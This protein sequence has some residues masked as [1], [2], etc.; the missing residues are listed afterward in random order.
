VL[1][2]LHF[3]FDLDISI[4]NIDP[5]IDPAWTERIRSID[6]RPVTPHYVINP[7]HLSGG[8]T[9]EGGRF[10]NWFGMTLGHYW[11]ATP[12]GDVLRYS[13]ET[14]WR[15]SLQSP[16]VQ[17]QVGRLFLDLQDTIPLSLDSVPPDIAA[18]VSDPDWYARSEAWCTI[19]DENADDCEFRRNLWDDALEWWHERV[20]DTSYLIG[21]QFFQMWRVKDDVFLRWWCSDK[22][23]KSAWRLPEGQIKLNVADFISSCYSFLDGFITA[24][25]KRVDGIER[26]G[27]H[28]A[29][30]YLNVAEV[31]QEQL[32]MEAL[33]NG[34]KDRRPTTDW[35]LVRS[36]LDVL[37]SHLE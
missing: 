37:R 24:M 30:C 21:G 26:D 25:R 7:S 20:F 33:V 19:D 10:L 35:G 36:R 23:W 18:V 11:I 4:E 14:V 12:L 32:N 28:R 5:W 2:Y 34:L 1:E 16:Y 3:C 22:D 27:W 17:Y 13:D 31:A 15:W 8:R 9:V 29:E 6:F